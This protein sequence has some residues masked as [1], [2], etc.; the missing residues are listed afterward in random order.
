VKTVN[1]LGRKHKVYFCVN[2]LYLNEIIGYVH[3]SDFNET[4]PKSS[5]DI[6]APKYVRLL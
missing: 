3:L 5:S 1:S 2:D 6:S 4:W